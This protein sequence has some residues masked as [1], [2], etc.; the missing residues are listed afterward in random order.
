MQTVYKMATESRR[1][2]IATDDRLAQD[3]R[4]SR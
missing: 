3:L 1:A 2:Y 4:E